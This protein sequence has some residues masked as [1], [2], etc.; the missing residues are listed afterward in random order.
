MTAAVNP[1][2]QWERTRKCGCGECR[3]KPKSEVC[4]QADEKHAVWLYASV[5]KSRDVDLEEGAQLTEV[6][7]DNSEQF[8]D[9]IPVETIYG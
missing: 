4:P 3:F 5:G 1:S 8:P 9:G 7:G 2:P 6:R